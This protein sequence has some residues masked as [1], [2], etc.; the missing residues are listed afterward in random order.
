M[1]KRGMGLLVYPAMFCPEW[2]F[3]GQLQSIDKGMS[4]G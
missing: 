4:N 1:N 3:D 2:L